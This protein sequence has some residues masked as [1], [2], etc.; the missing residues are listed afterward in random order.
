M[1]ELAEYLIKVGQE[2]NVTHD[3]VWLLLWNGHLLVQE[4]ADRLRLFLFENKV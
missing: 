2:I 1:L 4:E 3:V